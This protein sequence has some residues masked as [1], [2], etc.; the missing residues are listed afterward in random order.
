MIGDN[1]TLLPLQTF[2]F[3][4]PTGPHPNQDKSHPHQVILDPTEQ[5]IIVP[6]LGSDLLR[7]FKIDQ[8][9]SRFIEQDSIFVSP[10]YGPRHGAFL[11]TEDQPSERTYFFLISELGN[12][13]SSYA[14]SA[15]HGSLDFNLV[16]NY[17]VLNMS[18]PSGLFS[19]ELGISV[20]SQSNSTKYFLL[21]HLA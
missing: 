16:A 4:G 6:D 21:F 12:K 10:G 15:K 1:G 18:P 7:I 13:V 8:E 5:F 2:T 11:R 17:D 20:S 19:A 9:T 3:Q 14:V